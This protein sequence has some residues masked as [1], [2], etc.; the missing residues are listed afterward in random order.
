MPLPLLIQEVKKILRIEGAEHDDY[1]SVMVPSLEEWVRDY[2]NNQFIQLEPGVYTYPG[3]VK[4]F[5]A[6]ACEQN[7]QVTG[8][9]SRTMD[10]VSYT[11][12]LDFPETLKK[13]LRPYRRLRFHASR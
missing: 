9:K 10:T 7:M 4:I 12:E 2:C 1:L 6:K 11:Y 3:P 5:I 13:L 8:L